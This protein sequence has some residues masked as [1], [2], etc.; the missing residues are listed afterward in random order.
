MLQ[1]SERT[2]Q[3]VSQKIVFGIRKGLRCLGGDAIEMFQSS[4]INDV[5]YHK[6]GRADLFEVIGR[7]FL[8]SASLGFEYMGG[9]ILGSNIEMF[10]GP[11]GA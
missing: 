6:E 2:R 9:P 4:R 8:V 3:V 1:G 5:S 10:P 11:D 7:D